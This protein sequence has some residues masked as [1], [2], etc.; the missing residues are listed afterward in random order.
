MKRKIE[1]SVGENRISVFNVR[2]AR[3]MQC[4]KR[5]PYT[6]YKMSTSARR[7]SCCYLYLFVGPFA[8]S[9][10]VISNRNKS[11]CRRYSLSEFH[12]DRLPSIVTISVMFW[13]KIHFD[14]LCG[15]YKNLRNLKQSYIVNAVHTILNVKNSLQRVAKLR[16]TSTILVS[17]EFEKAKFVKYIFNLAFIWQ[18]QRIFHIIKV[19]IFL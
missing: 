15:K 11:E 17:L 4:M 7:S 3:N 18:L 8:D 16:D 19:S 9:Q 1:K 13:T 14:L 2:T 5:R 12:S 6:E 10:D